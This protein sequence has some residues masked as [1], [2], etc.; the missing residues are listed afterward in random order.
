MARDVTNEVHA[1]AGTGGDARGV[2]LATLE[3]GVRALRAGPRAR[4]GRLRRGPAVRARWPSA[5]RS[6]R[7]SSGY[8]DD[9]QRALERLTERAQASRTPWALG[10]LAR[11]RALLAGDA[12]A[13][14]LYVEAVLQLAGSG[15]AS[16]LA[17]SPNLLYGE[18]LRRVRRRRRD[19]RAQLRLAHDMLQAMGATRAPLTAPLVELL[20]TGRGTPARASRRHAISSPCRSSRSPSFAAG[21]ANPTPRSRR[22]CSSAR[23]TVAYHL[24]KVFGK[25][26]PARATTWQPLSTSSCRQSRSP[27]DTSCRGRGR[28][29]RGEP[30][31]VARARPALWTRRAPAVALGAR[32]RAGTTLDG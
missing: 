11:G 32:R 15:V 21:R 6:R 14:P 31:R 9:A 7:R 25:L 12:D 22:S 20:A 26:R 3:L 18:W 29:R 8:D 19:A 2:L 17:R 24:R 5:T 27:S 16:E 13:E 1:R 23:H 4:H 28:R 10:L 30:A